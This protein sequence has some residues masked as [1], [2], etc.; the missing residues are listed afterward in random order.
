MPIIKV[1]S[2][3]HA[4]E[5]VYAIIRN[6]M[7]PGFEL[8]TLETGSLEDRID[9]VKG[10][11][12]I[13]TAVGA[14]P[15]QVIEAADCLRMIQHQG[16]GVDKTDVDA[17]SRR[18]IE[19]CITPEGTST[20]VAEHVVLLILAVYKNIREVV[21]AMDR[22]EFPMWTLRNR[23]YQVYGKTIGFYGFGRIAREAAT[24]LAGF[25]PRIIFYDRYA[26][27]SEEE[28]ARYGATRV[29]SLD[30]L[31]AQ[32]DIVSV[33]TPAT[34]ETRGT[35]DAGFFAKMKPSA[36]FI[37]TARGDLLNEEDF[38][39]AMRK[40]VIAGAGIDVFA[41]EPLPADNQYITLPNVILTPHISAGT[42]DALQC[43]IRHAFANIQRYIDGEETSH[44][45]NKDQLVGSRRPSR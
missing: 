22:G 8:V 14:V 24:R 23:S 17:A 1:V 7:P 2:M 32:S 5:E 13:I 25:A 10:C 3:D 36:I 30:E 34:P 21:E 12:Y 45:V 40:R 9:K 19:I 6:T 39:A 41:K 16:V 44:S 11:E 20:G 27:I 29:D 18:G 15:T 26:D 35:I 43:K 38:F 37:N 33:H 28:M 4:S 42:V 31:L